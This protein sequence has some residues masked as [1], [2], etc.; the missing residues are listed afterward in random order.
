MTE[1]RRKAAAEWCAEYGEGWSMKDYVR[2]SRQNVD[3]ATMDAHLAGQEC[4][5]KRERERQERER[6]PIMQSILDEQYERGRLDER[7]AV[8]RWLRK[9][10]CYRDY[11]DDDWHNN[12][13]YTNV[14][15]IAKAIA[16]GE[17]RG[18]E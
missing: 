9:E 11:P 17:H 3:L 6:V 18:G 7:A 2:F 16:H 8:V 13:A 10:F 4:G 14:E 1:A 12:Y 5:E 15:V